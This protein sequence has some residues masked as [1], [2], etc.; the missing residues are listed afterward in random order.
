[1]INESDNR[2]NIVHDKRMKL[3]MNINDLKTIEQLEQFLTGKVD[4][5]VQTNNA[6]V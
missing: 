4:P 1:M 5:I 2:L 6:L 3:I